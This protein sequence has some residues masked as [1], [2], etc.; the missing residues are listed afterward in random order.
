MA[1]QFVY[2]VF[3]SWAMLFSFLKDVLALIS[4]MID[5]L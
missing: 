2:Y 4:N 5:G 3:T 1:D